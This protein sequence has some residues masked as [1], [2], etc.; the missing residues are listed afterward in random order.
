[1]GMAIYNDRGGL[2]QSF[3]KYL[4]KITFMVEKKVIQMVGY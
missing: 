2:G 4:S 3:K 1:M